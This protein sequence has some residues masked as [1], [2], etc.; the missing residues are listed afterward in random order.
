MK[1]NIQAEF[2]G[3]AHLGELVKSSRGE[4]MR[5]NQ[6]KIRYDLNPRFAVEQLAR[7]MTYGAT[8]YAPRNWEKG[9]SWTSVIASAKRHLAAVERGEDYDPETGLLHASHAMTNLAFL[10]EYYKIFPQGD[11]RNHKYLTMPKIGLDIDEVLADFVGTMVDKFPDQKK[12]A[13]FWNDPY[14]LDN[15]EKVKDD[16][17][18]WLS[19]KPLIDPNEL[20]F[21][22]F[23]Y[24]TSRPISSELSAKWLKM[25]GFPKAP[26]YTVTE[27]R[28]KVDIAK[29]VGLDIFVD[30]NYKNFVSLNKAGI[31]CFLFDAPHNQRYNVGHK[32]IKTLK[33]IV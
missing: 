8:K 11:D 13:I 17:D 15:F 6:G 3:K 31:C 14:L 24:I 4:G 23:C 22:P 2:N 16:K 30:D 18:F 19:I 29:E 20:P 21:E 10:T 25:N 5:F 1:G 12:R 33:D 7:V 9:M 27:N 26:V 28:S 32:R